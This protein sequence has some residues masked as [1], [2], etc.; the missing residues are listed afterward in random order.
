MVEIKMDG[1]GKNALGSE[2]M[3]SVLEQLEQAAGQPVL[4]TGTGDAFSAGLH[5]REVASLEAEGKYAVLK[6]L[7]GFYRS[8]FA[9]PG[10]IVAAVNGHAI[11]GGC[12]LAMVCDQRI[13]TTNPRTRMGLNEVNLGLRFSPVLKRLLQH[14]IDPCHISEA[15]LGAGL[16]DTQ[17]SLRLGFIDEVSDDPYRTAQERLT[18]L[19]RHPL[20]AYRDSKTDL[21]SGVMDDAPEDEAFFNE[22]VVPFWT[23]DDLKNRIQAVLNR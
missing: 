7:E 1:P 13:A 17:N 12:V 14:L 23:S 6:R 15:I 5:L 2:M 4:L 11:A 3:A 18:A 22:C 10:P 19:A 21:R 8:V 9:Y 20:E 16:H